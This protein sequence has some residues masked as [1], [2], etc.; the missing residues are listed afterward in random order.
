MKTS[1]VTQEQIDQW[2]EEGKVFSFNPYHV[3]RTKI[4]HP[5]ECMNG[6]QLQCHGW[7]L[8]GK[9]G[10]HFVLESCFGWGEESQV[11]V[12]EVEHDEF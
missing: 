10:D 6:D 2:C 7:F 1:E 11:I 12:T 5:S 4:N 8:V 3:V 9:E